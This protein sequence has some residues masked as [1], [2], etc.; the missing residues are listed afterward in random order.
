M[1]RF[2]CGTEKMTFNLA[3]GYLRGYYF[4]FEYAGY[5]PSESFRINQIEVK[6]SG[7]PMRATSFDISS[8]DRLKINE[9]LIQNATN[10]LLKLRP[11]IYDKKNFNWY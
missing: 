1:Y 5:S 6:A 11:Q 10:T 7:I 9:E 3:T 4:Y 8:D 2:D